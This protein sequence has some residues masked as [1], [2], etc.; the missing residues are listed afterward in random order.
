MTG[1]G[2]VDLIRRIPT[3][4]HNALSFATVNG[5]EVMAQD[6]MRLEETFI[7][8]RGRM[9]GSQDAG[10]IIVLPFDQ[11]VNLALNKP[12]KDTE[13]QAIFGG[14]N[15]PASAS[16]EPASDAPVISET[17]SEELEE[18]PEEGGQSL[19]TATRLPP[20]APPPKPENP[21][22]AP[23]SKSLL[24]DRLRQ[25]LAEQGKQH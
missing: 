3:K 6:I 17:P 19:S 2:W 4:L 20:N 13:V 10:Q 8:L 14:G 5:M 12:L 23:V 24:L 16:P 11:V 9:A 1:A 22:P 7:V 15:L 25:R 21:K 18:A